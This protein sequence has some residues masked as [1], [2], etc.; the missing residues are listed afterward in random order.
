MEHAFLW[1]IC[2]TCTWGLEM[3]FDKLDS[4]IS[5]IWHILACIPVFLQQNISKRTVRKRLRYPIGVENGETKREADNPIGFLT[6]E[7]AIE[8]WN[9][10]IE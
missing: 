9:R 7:E 2:T 4:S 1:N 6:K 3:V 10:R 8:A 5:D